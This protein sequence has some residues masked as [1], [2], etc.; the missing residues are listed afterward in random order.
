MKRQ[1]KEFRLAVRRIITGVAVA[2][3][4]TGSAMASGPHYVGQKA[5]QTAD[6]RAKKQVRE[7][8][9]FLRDQAGKTMVSGQTDYP[10]L[11]WVTKETGKTPLILNLDFMS[12]TTQMGKKVDSTQ[13]A[14]EWSQKRHGIVSYQWHWVS[15]LGAKELG[16]GFYTGSTTFNLATAMADPNSDAYKAILSDIDDVAAEMK[17]MD[18]AGVPIL[19]RPLHEAQGRW[20]WWGDKGAA[21]CVALYKLIYHRLTDFHRLHNL[22]F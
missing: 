15:P 19:F 3:I 20:F 10:D 4:A 22:V 2:T 8:L 7:M 1:R 11:E 18:R 16:K 9:T 6:R 17:K 5:F 14:I 12:Y 21:P 13:R